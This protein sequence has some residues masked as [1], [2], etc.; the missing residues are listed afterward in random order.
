MFSAIQALAE[1]AGCDPAELELLVRA[2]VELSD[3]PL[4][5][6]RMTF[7]GTAKQ[8]AADISATR[9]IGASELIMDAT[10]D[11]G[12]KSVED[13]LGCMELLFRLAKESLAGVP[14]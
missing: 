12:V 9:D 4:A 7:T 13:F 5:D 14:A 3:Q 1:E 6:E 8:V 11:P 10:F 2:N